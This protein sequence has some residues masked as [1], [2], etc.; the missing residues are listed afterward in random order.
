MLL[1]GNPG[2]SISEQRAQFA[3]WAIL[4]APL[5]ISTDLRTISSESLEILSNREVIGINQDALGKQGYVVFEDEHRRVWIKPLSNARTAVLFEN[6]RTIF[7]EIRF[8][9]DPDL[10][11]GWDNNGTYSVRDV[12]RHIDVVTNRPCQES[13][14]VDVDE[15][16]VELF[17]F[18]HHRSEPELSIV[19]EFQ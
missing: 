13:F 10:V 19:L 5:Y 8:K 7:N 14:T 6:K 4:A 17:I 1:V 9:F 11:L 15:S 18:T 12:H 16:C 3:L 2:L